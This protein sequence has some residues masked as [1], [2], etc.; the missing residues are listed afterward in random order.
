MEQNIL[1]WFLRYILVGWILLT[2]AVAR[3][4][5]LPTFSQ[6]QQNW[7]SSYATL[8]DRNG[9]VLIQQRINKQQHRF[10][11]TPLNEVS[12]ALLDALLFVEDKDFYR[13]HGVDCKAYSASFLMPFGA[14]SLMMPWLSSASST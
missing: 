1:T 3:A 14:S 2:V 5:S 6:V 7:Q 9:Q 12:P 10:D 13:H 11:W 8:L 4:S